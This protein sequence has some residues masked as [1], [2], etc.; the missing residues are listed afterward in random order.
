MLETVTVLG[1]DNCCAPNYVMRHHLYNL[2][3]YISGFTTSVRLKLVFR[4][5]QSIGTGVAG[6]LINSGRETVNLL[7]VR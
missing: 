1:P 4:M 7:W 5:L 6:T 3:I 2:I